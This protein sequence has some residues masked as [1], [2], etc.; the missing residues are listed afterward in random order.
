MPKPELWISDAFAERPFTGTPAAVCVLAA[1]AELGWMQAVAAEM[2]Q[3][4]TAFVHR[5]GDGWRLR[6]FTP[7]TEV[8][9]CGHA[10]LAT[11]VALWTAGH[12]AGDSEI[13]FTTASGRLSCRQSGDAVAMD[14]PTVTVEPMV[15]PDDLL[16]ALGVMPLTVGRAGEDW[17]CEL[18]SADTVRGLEPDLGTIARLS[19]RG[20]IITAA[21]SG[22]VDFVSRFFAPAVGIPEDP[23]TG[24]AH[25]ALGPWWGRRLRRR[26]VRGAQVSARGGIVTVIDRGERVSLIGG[27][28]VIARGQLLA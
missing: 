10:T 18:D 11:A 16:G 21:G 5:G 17:L 13:G 19:G 23:V 12:E 20:V 28:Q 15:A 4:E 14:F 1:A 25:C 7:R 3:A 6:W 24:S 22:D 8:R 2:N 27:A 26:E 9:L